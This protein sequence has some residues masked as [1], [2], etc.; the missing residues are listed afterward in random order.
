MTLYERKSTTWSTNWE[1]P[2]TK[3][4]WCVFFSWSAHAVE[5]TI[6]LPV[7]WNTMTLIRRHCFVLW[8]TTTPPTKTGKIIHVSKEYRR[9]K[10]LSMWKKSVTS[11]FLTTLPLNLN[12]HF[13]EA[14]DINTTPTSQSHTT[15]HRPHTLNM[16]RSYSKVHK[17][18]IPFPVLSLFY[19]HGLTLIPAWV[20]DH[21]PSRLRGMKLLIHSQTSTVAPLKFGNG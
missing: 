12:R 1:F 10:F 16:L 13:Y 4:R 5:E 2:L 15:P 21:I 9:R 7:T 11:N 18:S 20:S 14:E 6:E 19:W 17:K 3:R 8:N